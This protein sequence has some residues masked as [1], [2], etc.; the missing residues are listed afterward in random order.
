MCDVCAWSSMCVCVQF[1]WQEGASTHGPKSVCGGGA[2]LCGCAKSSLCAH[3]S[4]AARI[5]EPRRLFQNWWRMTWSTSCTCIPAFTM[6]LTCPQRNNRHVVEW[7]AVVANIFHMFCKVPFL[8]FC[9]T[10]FLA[11]LLTLFLKLFLTV[12]P[13]SLLTFFLA[14]LLTSVS[15]YLLTF[16][17]T[18]FLAYLLAF[19]H[20][21]WQ[22]FWQS[23]PAS[24]LSFLLTVFLT[25]SDLLSDIVCIPLGILSEILSCISSYMWFKLSV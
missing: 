6:I 14:H 18:F 21:F 11:Y 12:F 17:L 20:L 3:A 24:L 19:L 8:P 22:S 1:P 16:C 9:L 10:L 23:F 15:A 4:A 2:G 7:Q 25:S 13:A 5:R